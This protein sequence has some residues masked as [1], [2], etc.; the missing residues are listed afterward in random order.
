MKNE[1]ELKL[2]VSADFAAFLS[3]EISAFRILAQETQLLGNCYYDTPQRL[4]A[5]QH[6]GLRV[7]KA[8]EGY[9][10]TLKTDGKSLGGL[11][12]RPEYNVELD[13]PQP[14]L[15][16]LVDACRLDP[17]WRT[18]T[19]QPIFATDFARRVWLVECGNGVVV[20]I[21]LDQGEI[22]AGDKREPICEVEFELKQGR[23]EDLLHFVAA[24]S[25]ENGV[26]LSAVSKAQRGYRLAQQQTTAEVKNWLD[27]WREFLQ[28]AQQAANSRQKLTAL[29]QLEQELI[30]ETMTLGAEYLAQDFLRTVE[31]IGAFFNLYHFY[32]ENSSLL[33]GALHERLEQGAADDE[34]ENLTAIVESNAR[35]LSQ[36]KAIICLHS[37]NKNNRQALDKLLELL[38][39]V[40]YVKR[41]LHL[42]FLTLD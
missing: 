40:L 12:I 35:L 3:Q 38:Q 16:K 39:S 27:S 20:E 11:H 29:F 32:T 5:A 34:Q 33:E 25:L 1:V 7:R 36:I 26:R 24:L 37:E 17:A 42:I 2:A 8:G 13:N 22:R 15:P 31:R 30:E 14:D 23:I 4:F 19:L 28:F 9:T 6:M 18:L 41:M 10:F 21:A